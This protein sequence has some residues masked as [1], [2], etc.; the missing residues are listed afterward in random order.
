MQYR[1]KHETIQYRKHETTFNSNENVSKA[2]KYWPVSKWHPDYYYSLSLSLPLS[3][4]HSR[5]KKKKTNTITQHVIQSENSIGTSIEWKV[6]MKI[7]HKLEYSEWNVSSQ[8]VSQAHRNEM[9]H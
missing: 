1:W 8:P 3:V 6:K 7:K 4:T 9:K 5:N 2:Y